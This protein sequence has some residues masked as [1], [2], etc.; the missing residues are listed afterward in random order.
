MKAEHV[1]QWAETRK[2]G[3]FAFLLRTG[4]LCWGLPMCVFFVAMHMY[5]LPGRFLMI[6]AL[7]VPIWSVGGLLFGF[8]MWTINEWQYERFI[9]KTGQSS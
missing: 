6:L 3:R 8:V 2:R 1:Q 4:L 9:S 5:L 7:N